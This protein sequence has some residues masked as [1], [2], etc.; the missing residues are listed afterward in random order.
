MSGGRE[1]SVTFHVDYI[2][3]FPSHKTLATMDIIT[4]PHHCVVG[5]ALNAKKLRKSSHDCSIGTRPVGD[6]SGNTSTAICTGHEWRGGGLADILEQKCFD[7][8]HSIRSIIPPIHFVAFDHE[9]PLT[10]LPKFDVII[11][12]TSCCSGF[13]SNETAGSQTYNLVVKYVR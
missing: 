5:Y 10:E 8:T 3:M 13:C 11:P 1:V 4:S 9:I 12:G 6:E 7:E 2:L